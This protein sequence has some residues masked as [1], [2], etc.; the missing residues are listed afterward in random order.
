MTH[1]VIDPIISKHNHKIECFTEVGSIKKITTENYKGGLLIDY[2]FDLPKGERYIDNSKQIGLREGE[3][4]IVD[5]S[6]REDGSYIVDNFR[7]K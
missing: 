1:F 2:W 5:W 6:I 4:V 3:S 7:L